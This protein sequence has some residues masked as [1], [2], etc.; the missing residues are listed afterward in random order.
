MLCF[1]IRLLNIV[2][3]S[4]QYRIIFYFTSLNLD[5]FSATIYLDHML[6]SFPNTPLH[7]KNEQFWWNL[8][9]NFN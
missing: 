4:L 2:C 7:L 1:F 8:Q 3:I 9:E 5:I 6:Q